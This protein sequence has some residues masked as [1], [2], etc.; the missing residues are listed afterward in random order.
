MEPTENGYDVSPGFLQSV[1]LSKPEFNSPNINVL[2]HQ[3]LNN[4]NTTTLTIPKSDKGCC[5]NYE[6]VEYS[7][8]LD[9]SDMDVD[10]WVKIAQDISNAYHN[11]DGFIVLHG[12]DTMAYTASALSFMLGNLAKPVVI[13][14]SQIP[15]SQLRN[16]AGDN[17][18]EALLAVADC[19]VPEVILC[20]HHKLY[21]GNR[22][23]KSSSVSLNA[24]DS[25]NFPPLGNIGINL[26]IDW[27]RVC[28]PNLCL[29]FEPITKM[30]KEVGILYLFPGIMLNV[31]QSFLESGLKGVVLKTFGAGN[32]S[33]KP[34]ILEAFTNAS[35]RGIV[36]VNSTQCLSGRVEGTYAAGQALATAGIVPVGDITTEAALTK[37]SF[38]LAQSN[39]TPGEV[40]IKMAEN[41]RGELS[42]PEHESYSFR[43]TAFVKAVAVAMKETTDAVNKN[44]AC[45]LTPII[46]CT[47]AYENQSERIEE[48]LQEKGSDPNVVDYDGRSAMHLA[49]ASGNLE[50]LDVLFKYGASVSNRD[51]FGHTPLYEACIAGQSEVVER[52]INCE[53]HLSLDPKEACSIYCHLGQEGNLE[54]LQLWAQAGADFNVSDYDGRS[55]LH[56]AHDENNEKIKSLLFSYGAISN[57]DRWGNIVSN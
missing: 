2:K 18:L 28:R 37:L 47:Y 48:L 9:S 1:C 13:T 34:S 55:P 45:A 32:F 12:T 38:L 40:R 25:P 15:M 52:L 53:A 43:N 19:E 24:F 44:I 56:I 54:Y 27:D 11:Y 36:L 7:P 17:L 23:T 6:I 31:V 29:P 30:S 46:L 5:I 20:F 35:K 3:T 33:Q 26:I 16:D 21:R 22:T 49:C 10:D 41:L 8:L 42:P 14:G 39:L 4:N 50:T 57:S 51:S